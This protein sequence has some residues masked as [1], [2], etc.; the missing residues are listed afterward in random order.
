MAGRF[1][2]AIL[3]SVNRI[4]Q[5]LCSHLTNSSAMITTISS[6]ATLLFS[7]STQSLQENSTMLLI[8]LV[9]I[10]LSLLW[11][12]NYGSK[13]LATFPKN[14]PVFRMPTPFSPYWRMKQI[15]FRSHLSCS[16]G[17]DAKAQKL[18][19]QF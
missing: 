14:C 7:V 5:L 6:A 13:L 12:C 1:P 16:Q 19:D 11:L 10:A 17:P 9:G 2:K 3:I 4:N 8:F 15:I 18:Y